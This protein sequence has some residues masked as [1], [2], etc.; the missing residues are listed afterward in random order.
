MIFV[1]ELPAAA[2]PR[3]WFAFDEEDLL[4]KVAAADIEGLRM[5]HAAL[6]DCDPA[7][8]AE[9]TLRARGDCRIYGDEA[10]AMAAFERRDDPAWQGS[11]GWR[12]HRALREQLLALE[13]LADDC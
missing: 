8:L 1:V 5:T 12:A 11:G 13:V 9:A 4:R 3:A 6:G 10:Q 7:A 2:D